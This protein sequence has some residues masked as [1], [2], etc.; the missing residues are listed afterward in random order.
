VLSGLKREDLFT[1]VHEQFPTDTV[2]YADIVLPAT[3]QLEHFDLH[4]AYGHHWV[5]VNQPCIAELAEARSNTWVFRQLAARLGFEP[6]VFQ[7]TDEE[8]AR[9]ALWE[10]SSNTPY[11]LQGI[12]LDRLIAEGPQRL[13]IPGRFTPFA[14]GRFPTESGKCELYSRRMAQAG[15]DP[16]P[17]YTPPAESAEADPVLARRYP[18]QMISP[19]SPHFL[20][21][22]FVNI[23][24]LRRAARRPE[25]EMHRDDAARRNIC[26]GE[27]VRVINDR[28]SFEALAVVGD[29]V[30][31]GVVVAPGIW[32]NKLAGDGANANSTTSS[33]LTDMGGGA[34]FFDNL[35]EVVPAGTR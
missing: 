23:D 28:G 34:T 9:E 19:P 17:G 4:T 2:D 18:L 26:D 6:D 8:L 13:N 12:T 33:R 5:Q 20:N 32:W 16:L 11:A 3:T 22:T 10:R 27:R 30:R 1:V 15:L 31:P 7:V 24:S 35:V 29:S 21:S 14:D 25:L